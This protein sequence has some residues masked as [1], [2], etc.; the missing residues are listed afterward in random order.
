[1]SVGVTNVD[2]CV[3]VSVGVY[4]INVGVETEDAANLLRCLQNPDVWLHSVTPQCS[5][6]YL[7]KLQQLREEK[8]GAGNY[9][10]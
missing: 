7:Q 3:I 10:V 5:D 8:M 6:T 2:W 9:S 4:A 1:M